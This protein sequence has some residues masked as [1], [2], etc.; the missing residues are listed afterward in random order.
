LEFYELLKKAKKNP[1]KSILNKLV[2]YEFNPEYCEK[3]NL[4]KEFSE[5]I[6]KVKKENLEAIFD[7][8]EKFIDCFSFKDV[9]DIISTIVN[10]IDLANIIEF[11]RDTS[12]YFEEKEILET[13]K[14][15]KTKKKSIAVILLPVITNINHTAELVQ[16]LSSEES[17][18]KAL[19]IFPFIENKTDKMSII[20]CLRRII[21]ERK[22]I[23]VNK[24]SSFIVPIFY[25]SIISPETANVL[26]ERI[27]R[28]IKSNKNV[29]LKS[30]AF[31]PNLVEAK[32][33]L[34]VIS[35]YPQIFEPKKVIK[36]II[37]SVKNHGQNIILD[38][39][40]T[41]TIILQRLDEESRKHTIKI[42]SRS[43][44][45]ELRLL[46]AHLASEHIDD[47]HFREI[48]RRLSI[49]KKRS[50]RK[51]AAS[52]LLNY[53]PLIEDKEELM[54]T[55]S[56]LILSGHASTI[57]KTLEILSMMELSAN[58]ITSIIK[59]VS[60]DYRSS[61]I[62]AII[63]LIELYQDRLDAKFVIETLINLLKK[64]QEKKNLSEQILELID[65]ILTQKEKEAAKFLKKILKRYKLKNEYE[66][67]LQRRIRSIFQK[68]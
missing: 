44:I 5:L 58:D 50:I 51:V 37:L 43:R 33:L 64:V 57:R 34:W 2:K 42:L 18:E 4:K 56:Y 24:L 62:N 30:L 13:Y 49:D 19:L 12:K 63:K 22:D 15:F 29:L 28:I 31:A 47:F 26:I 14:E 23:I 67:R 45:D 41:L 54:R 36:S 52:Y 21:E 20:A 46:A 9:I 66:K 8:V 60:F 38:A 53:L 3:I 7:L 61:T 10:N 32:A 48:L 68:Q 17:M 11:L 6:R 25:I 35:K 40:Q 1:S 39:S 16:F 65:T 59:K 27:Y 55:V